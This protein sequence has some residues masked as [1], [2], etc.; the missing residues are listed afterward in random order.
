MHNQESS[1]SYRREKKQKTN[2]QLNL[3]KELGTNH[4]LE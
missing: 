2:N 1:H 3:T 4:A